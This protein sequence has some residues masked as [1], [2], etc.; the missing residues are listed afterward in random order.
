MPNRVQQ[1]RNE[2]NSYFLLFF[3]FQLLQESITC[4]WIGLEELH[5]TAAVNSL[6]AA[7]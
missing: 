7:V 6:A 4:G 2:S 5:S 1:G 3:L